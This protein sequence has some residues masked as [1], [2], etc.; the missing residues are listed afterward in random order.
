MAEKKNEVIT[1]RTEAW[2]KNELQRVADFNKWSVAQTANQIIANYLIN[3]QPERITVKAEDLVKAAIAIRKEGT[4]KGVEL[5]I[6]LIQ[7][8]ETQITNKYLVYRVIECGGLG[9][10][11]DF[12]PLKE[13]SNE[14]ILDIP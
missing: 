1:F 8:E 5:S 9:C 6:D 3:P 11:G 13:M 4:N 10:C 2:V 14:E 7:D 12:E